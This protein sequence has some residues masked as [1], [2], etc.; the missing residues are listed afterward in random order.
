MEGHKTDESDAKEIEDFVECDIDTNYAD[1][2][3][4]L[5][6]DSGVE[7]IVSP[8]EPVSNTSILK[9]SICNILRLPDKE[10]E[11]NHPKTSDSCLPI[12]SSTE[13][14]TSDLASSIKSKRN[15]TTFST[16]QLQELE[17]VFRK[18]HYPDVFL[19]EKLASKIKLPESRIQV[20]FQNRRAKWRKREKLALGAGFVTYGLPFSLSWAAHHSSLMSHSALMTSVMELTNHRQQVAQEA[21]KYK[22]FGE[23]SD[24]LNIRHTNPTFKRRTDM[25]SPL[26]AQRTTCATEESADEFKHIMHFEEVLVIFFAKIKKCMKVTA[27]CE[28]M[29]FGRGVIKSNEAR[30][31][32]S[33]LKRQAR[34]KRDTVGF[35][36]SDILDTLLSTLLRPGSSDQ[37]SNFRTPFPRLSK[38]KSSLPTW[39]DAH[40]IKVFLANGF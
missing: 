22:A 29:I 15:R 27:Y 13:H 16:K 21:P 17:K 35:A 39:K 40:K 25:L 32:Y 34:D 4:A 36:G 31:K 11:S 10:R 38:L 30:N 3:I 1:D 12:I 20:W 18:T 14:K 26:S 5:D 7:D 6:T 9:F 24:P 2:V 33:I 8:R 28:V 37:P 19:R 23:Q